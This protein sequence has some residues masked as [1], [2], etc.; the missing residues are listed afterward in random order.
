MTLKINLQSRGMTHKTGR[1]QNAK[2][3]APR[4]KY[5]RCR[6]HYI[7]GQRLPLALLRRGY[8]RSSVPLCD[9]CHPI[10]ATL[11]SELHFL[12]L[13]FKT[14]HKKLPWP[15]REERVTVGC[16]RRTLTWTNSLQE[17]LSRLTHLHREQGG[18]QKLRM[19]QRQSCKR[20]HF[21]ELGCL[22]LAACSSIK[23]TCITVSRGV[24]PHHISFSSVTSVVEYLGL[25]EGCLT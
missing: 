14:R 4:P 3:L 1:R 7:R 9:R 16:L 18:F 24:F 8:H 6:R 13:R 17:R 10:A 19:Q 23:S 15:R 22:N 21:Y 25:S 12:R 5:P 20:V 2:S 11:Q